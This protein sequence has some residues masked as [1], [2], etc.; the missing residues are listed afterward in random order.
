MRHTALANDL[1]AQLWRQ[2]GLA[3][4]PYPRRLN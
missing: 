3:P 2:T 1:L 4:Q